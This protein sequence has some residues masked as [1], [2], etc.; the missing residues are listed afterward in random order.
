MILLDGA[1]G[2]TISNIYKIKDKCREKL[3]YTNPEIVTEIHER[4]VKAGACYLKA[5]T[6]N[7]SKEALKNYGENP[8]MAYEY[9]LLGGKICK[10][11]ADKYGKTSIGTF[12]LPDKDQI[13]GIL[14]SGVDKVMIE[15]IYNLDKGLESLKL[16][17]ERME[18]KKI[19]KVI[20]VSFAVDKDGKL[21]SGENLI[22]VY[23]KFLLENVVFIGINC[24][25]LTEKVVDILKIFRKKTGLIVSFHPNSN[26][27]VKKFIEDIEILLKQGVVY[28]IGGCCGTDFRH[29]EALRKSIEKFEEEE[30]FVMRWRNQLDE[31]EKKY[32]PVQRGY[33][34]EGKSL[35][36]YLHTK[37]EKLAHFKDLLARKIITKERYELKIK[38]V[39]EGLDTDENYR[40]WVDECIK[41]MIKK[42]AFEKNS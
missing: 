36:D 13:D 42:G 14:D 34:N 4:Y 26:G 9:A 40:K 23:R 18:I 32:P 39:E 33:G 16:L 30:S 15:T 1:M 22:D 10:A 20:M 28:V 17:E 41:D 5:N 6:F 19:K 35:G 3:N 27:D 25:E 24:S 29:I 11:V 21:Y 8:E 7:C 37:E 31:N 12:C 38:E 2:T